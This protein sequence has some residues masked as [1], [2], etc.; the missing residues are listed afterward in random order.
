MVEKATNRHPLDTIYPNFTLS[1]DYDVVVELWDTIEQLKGLDCLLHFRHI[2]G[3]QDDDRRYQDLPLPAQLN[4]QADDSLAG[5]FQRQ[6]PTWDYR[7]APVLPS[8]NV[9]LH[10]HEGS[11]THH[12]KQQ[13]KKARHHQPLINRM[14]RRNGWNQVIANSI[15]W[16]AHRI[17]L[18]RQEHHRTTLIK[19]LHGWLPVG[20]VVHRYDKKYEKECPSCTSVEE[21]TIGHLPVCP[22]ELREQ[23]R[24]ETLQETKKKM[25][26]LQTPFPIQEMFLNGLHSALYGTSPP[27]S[28]D[29]H[30]QVVIAT[31]GAI[32]WDQ[33]LK[34]RLSVCWKIKMAEHYR[35]GSDSKGRDLQWASAMATLMISQWWKLWTLRNEARHGKDLESRNNAMKRQALREITQL[36]ELQES[37]RIDLQW[38][39]NTPLASIQNWTTS[40]MR[41]WINNYRPILLEGYNTALETG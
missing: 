3:H 8:S 26:A 33:L 13:L 15:D 39:Y 2:A 25:R 10:L 18:G 34:G 14:C 24:K 11:V 23:W 22:G 19:Y 41:A 21:E 16:D 28:E 37:R 12:L 30:L 1:S 5:E 35:G 20:R 17:A 4:V 40:M 27:T 32:G 7:R 36:Y 31:Q 9:Q 38:I 6:H 29:Q